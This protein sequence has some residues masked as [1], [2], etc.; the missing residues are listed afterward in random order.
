MCGRCS[1]KYTLLVT[2]LRIQHNSFRFTKIAGKLSACANSITYTVVELSLT[3][4]LNSEHLY[5][6]HFVNPDCPSIQVASELDTP[7]L[8]KADTFCSL[9][10]TQIILNDSNFLD[11]HLPFLQDSLLLQLELTN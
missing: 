7:L 1:G 4:T 8:R 9:N 11:T 10:C 2:I 5:N 3:D 6:E